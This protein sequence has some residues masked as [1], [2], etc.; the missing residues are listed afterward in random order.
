MGVN[1]ASLY[2]TSDTDLSKLDKKKQKEIEDMVADSYVQTIFKFED[3]AATIETKN[4]FSDALMKRM[5]LN[6]DGKAP[7]LAKLGKGDPRFGLSVNIDMKKMQAFMDE[8][9][10]DAADEWHEV[11]GDLHKWH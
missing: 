1:V 6:A 10:P 8:F 7:L 11:W 2:N 4:F 3:G 9:S 5:F